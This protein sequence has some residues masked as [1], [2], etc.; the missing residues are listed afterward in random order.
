MV[1]IDQT[2]AATRAATM[3]KTR[4]LFWPENSI[5]RSIMLVT[6]GRSRHGPQLA[7]RIDQ[8]GARDHDPLALFQSFANF[9]AVP[10]I[11]SG[12][13]CARLEKAV[14]S[15]DKHGL[16]QA[17]VEYRI[18]GYGQPRSQGDVELDI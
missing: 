15:I 13:D 5:I 17:G 4:N 2:P 1:R 10:E 11:L 6:F 8:E 18:E 7:F 9:D 14:T 16:T 3:T 12:F